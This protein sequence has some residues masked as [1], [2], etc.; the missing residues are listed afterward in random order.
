[1]SLVPIKLCSDVLNRYS[2]VLT[3]LTKKIRNETSKIRLVD[4]QVIGFGYYLSD[5]DDVDRRF[6]L[7]DKVIQFTSF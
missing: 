1:M 3:S 5:E 7:N 4:V 2:M 6:V